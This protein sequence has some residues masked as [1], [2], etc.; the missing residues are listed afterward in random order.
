MRPRGPR[1]GDGRKRE[2][3]Q[4]AQHVCLRAGGVAPGTCVPPPQTRRGLLLLL[5]LLLLQ[6]AAC[7]CEPSAD[8]ASLQC[9]NCGDGS[10]DSM[11]Y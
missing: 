6:G 2:D 9:G 1:E 5:L 8:A 4:V 10:W 11:A 7:V 3:A